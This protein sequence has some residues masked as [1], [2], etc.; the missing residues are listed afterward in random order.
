MIPK[1]LFITFLSLQLPSSV[2]RLSRHEGHLAPSTPH[3]AILPAADTDIV[4][5]HAEYTRSPAKPVATSGKSV[6]AYAK[7]DVGTMAAEIDVS[8]LI[9]ICPQQ[10][11]TAC[12]HHSARCFA[13]P[14]W[15][16][17]LC[18]SLLSSLAL[19]SLSP[20]PV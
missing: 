17:Q 4:T 20:Y 19:S 9:I 16:L 15:P 5:I 6:K 11:H 10:S 8:I 14:Y 3:A 12:L 18:S 13:A 2:P 1:S 7:P